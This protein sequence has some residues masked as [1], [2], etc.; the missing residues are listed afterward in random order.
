MQCSYGVMGKVNV[1]EISVESNETFLQR[2]DSLH[3][4]HPCNKVEI[5]MAILSCLIS[6]YFRKLIKKVNATFEPLE[7]IKKFVDEWNESYS[8]NMR[9][10][11]LDPDNQQF[12]KE[13]FTSEL[14]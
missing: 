4:R 12:L 7:G 5:S 1:Y 14:L 8:K 2:E 9:K 11:L 13:L 6:G 3:S 10:A